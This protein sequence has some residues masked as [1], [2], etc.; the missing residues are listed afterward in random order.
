MVSC[1][2]LKNA[3]FVFKTQAV[4]GIFEHKCSETAANTGVLLLILMPLAAHQHMSNIAV[5]SQVHSSRTTSK[6]DLP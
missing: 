1:Q 5:T 2:I 4:T 3:W 6:G